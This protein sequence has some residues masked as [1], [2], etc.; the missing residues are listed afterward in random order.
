MKPNYGI[1]A[2]GLVAMFWTAAAV[3][4]P[5][6]AAAWALGPGGWS[7]AAGAIAVVAALHPLGVGRGLLLVGAA[8]RVPK[9]Q[10]I[11]VDIWRG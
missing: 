11:G 8:H 6:G 9:G 10:A 1:D 3:L 7:A 2:P 4:A 5:G